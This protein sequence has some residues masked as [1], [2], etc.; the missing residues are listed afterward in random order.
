MLRDWSTSATI[1]WV[2]RAP[3][4]Y[5]IGVWLRDST[6]TADLGTVNRSVAFT[7]K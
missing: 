4:G 2:P 5:R 1:S 7:V 6:T 3:G